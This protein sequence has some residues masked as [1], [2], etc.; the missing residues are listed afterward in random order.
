[1]QVKFKSENKTTV[2]GKWIFPKKLC[3]NRII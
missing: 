2:T 3:I 1:M